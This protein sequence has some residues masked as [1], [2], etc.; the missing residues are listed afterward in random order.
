M[1][2]KKNKEIIV[3]RRAAEGS[4]SVNYIFL[5]RGQKYINCNDELF[6]FPASH[7]KTKLIVSL[8]TPRLCGENI[9]VPALPGYER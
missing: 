7:R 9:S 5:P 1:M 4:E 8:R 6:C 2:H 3:H